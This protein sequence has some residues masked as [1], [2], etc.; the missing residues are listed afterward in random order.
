MESIPL[1]MDIL[2]VVG[3]GSE[4]DN[5]ELRYSLR[6][7]AKN[8][9]NIGRVFLVGYKPEW[10]NDA[11][12]HIPCDDPYG[13]PHK[14]ILHK[15]LTAAYHSS[16]GSHFIISS[17]DHYYMRPTDFNKLP[18]YYRE[19]EIPEKVRDSWSIYCNSLHDTR[20]ILLDAGLTIYQTNP[21]CNTHFDVGVYEKNKSIF[22]LC[23]WLPNGGEL[24]CVMGNLLI[25]EGWKAAHFDDAK[26][27]S[28][29]TLAE[30]E[31]IAKKRECLSSVPN[32]ANSALAKYL[33]KEFDKKCKYEI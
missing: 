17:D 23:M 24:N 30:V 19:K 12:I 4:W 20:N 14:N 29:M 18:I 5:N 31:Q 8:G 2:Y 16:I 33:E 22:D 21:H 27:S 26:L 3:T 28:K 7:I 1:V 10:V 11:V 9:K 6:S 15:V 25:K 13:Q 32:I